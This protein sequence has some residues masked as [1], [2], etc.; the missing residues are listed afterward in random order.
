[1]NKYGDPIWE[2]IFSKREWGIYPYE[3]VVKFYKL[4]NSKF[5]KKPQVLD[6]GAGMGANSWFMAKEG[7]NI[8]ALEGSKSAI[9]KIN[10]IKKRF[11]VSNKIKIFNGNILFPKKILSRKFD[12]LVD[13]LSLCTNEEKA[14][15]SAYKDYFD[16]MN[17]NAQFL[18]I[19]LGQKTTGYKSGEKLS[20][21]TWKN[22][23]IGCMK[24]RGIITWYNK[25]YLKNMF[26]KIGFKISSYTNLIQDNNGI[27]IEK[28]IFNLTLN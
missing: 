12:I 9:K 16:L 7:G 14:I 4:N 20:I 11:N 28:N 1:M 19:S 23:P 21:R 2:K 25:K 5:K 15:Q 18:T 24:K 3:E 17:K 8:T 22:V 10:I 13:N 27:I 26:I 6:I